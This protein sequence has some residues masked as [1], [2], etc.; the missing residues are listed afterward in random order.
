[1]DFT[2][3]GAFV[4]T[5]ELVPLA[6]A[7]DELGYHSFC[8]GDHVVDLETIATP[9]PYE[10]SGDRRWDHRA[11]WPDPWVLFGA[12]AAVTTNLSFFTS[13]Y[14]ASLRSPFQVAKSVGTAAVL[15]GGRVR[16]GVGAGWCREEFELLGQDFDSR[17]KRTDEGLALLR[18]LWTQEWAESDPQSGA[19]HYPTPRLTMRP[20]PKH[21]VPILVGGLTPVALRRAARYDGWVGDIS[22]TED[23]IGIAARLREIRERTGEAD[24]PRPTVVAALDDAF[25]PE[26]FA[27]A[28]AGGVT[29]V[30][31]QPWMYYF[32]RNASLDQKLDGLERF[33]KDVL[34]PLNG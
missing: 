27:A 32:G 23:A 7:A 18:T 26:H 6:R 1:M 30:M 19:V 12:M 13:I 25:L 33:A 29:D 34:V 9:Y 16:L 11:E 24:R 20:L 17:G 15:S 14:V 8:V 10:A 21:P 22:S 4:P 5:E 3:V 2:I 31:T 28:E